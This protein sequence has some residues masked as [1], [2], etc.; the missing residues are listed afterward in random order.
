MTGMENI[1]RAVAKLECRFNAVGSVPVV[2]IGSA[3][4][5]SMFAS[6]Q[7]I[8]GIACAI[9]GV[10]GQLIYS[11]TESS[12]KWEEQTNFGM[13]HTFHGFLNGWRATGELLA[14]ITFVGSL[15]L[16]VWQTQRSEGFKPI[17]GYDGNVRYDGNVG[18]L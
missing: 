14:A 4:V 8:A 10:I 5:R 15:G 2:A 7:M 12:S 1:S 17:I 13:Q 16:L 9:V 18:Q 3:V 11:N 6:A